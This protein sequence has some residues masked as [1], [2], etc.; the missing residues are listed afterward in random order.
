MLKDHQK[1]V[2][3]DAFTKYRQV[4]LESDG[5]YYYGKVIHM[6]DDNLTLKNKNNNTDHS[7]YYNDINKIYLIGG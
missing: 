5:L 6:S 3:F 7:F 4:C 1:A 2:L